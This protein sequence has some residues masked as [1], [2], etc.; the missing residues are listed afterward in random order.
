MG[1]LKYF[2]EDHGSFT[3]KVCKQCQTI[4]TV[5]ILLQVYSVWK[6]IWPCKTKHAPYTIN[7][8]QFYGQVEVASLNTST[9]IY[10]VSHITYQI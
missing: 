5:G 10:T 8:G 1:L 9:A 3:A 6:S 7:E 4:W 2:I